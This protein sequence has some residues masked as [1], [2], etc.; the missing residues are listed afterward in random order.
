[1]NPD[2]GLLWWLNT[3]GALRERS[4][5]QFLCPR[6]RGQ[7][8]LGR[9]RQEFV[10]VLRWTDPAATDTFIRLI[11]QAVEDEEL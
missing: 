4:G 1:M 9:A 5:R 11:M 2:Y 10:A 7:S 8:D 3:G 6:R